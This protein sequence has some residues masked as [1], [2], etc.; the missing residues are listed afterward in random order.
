MNGCLYT[1]WLGVFEDL[2][3]GRDPGEG[4][5][6]VVVAVDEDADGVDEVCDAGE[7]AAVD[8]LEVLT[9]SAMKLI[10]KPN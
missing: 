2:V 9:M 10:H 4:V 3:C 1:C 5:A 6:A 7:A 8:G